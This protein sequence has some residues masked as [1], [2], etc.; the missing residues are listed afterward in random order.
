MW[1]EEQIKYLNNGGDSKKGDKTICKNYRKI[2]RLDVT[3][4]VLARM[5]RK[6]SNRYYKKLVG[7]YQESFRKGRFLRWKWSK[8]KVL[9]K[10]CAFTIHVLFIVFKK[11]Y[12]SI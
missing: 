7:E 4:K 8:T 9:K 11:T 5:I 6:W 2:L 1:Q 12:N 10:T 3:Y